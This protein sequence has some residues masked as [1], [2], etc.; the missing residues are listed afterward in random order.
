MEAGNVVAL[1]TAQ[2]KA[3]TQEEWEEAVKGIWEEALQG[4]SS[5]PGFKGLVALWNSDSPGQVII[6]GIW[7]NMER[8]LAYEARSSAYVRSLFNPLFQQV[9]D[10]PRFIVSRATFF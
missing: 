3:R 5:N 7:E 1:L 9:P 4:L 2:A 6:Y 10:R 8:R